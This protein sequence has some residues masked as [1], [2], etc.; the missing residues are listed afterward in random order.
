ML[1]IFASFLFIIVSV[2]SGADGRVIVSVQLGVQQIHRLILGQVL[3]LT[4]TC[5]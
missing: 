4:V 3:A 5:R 2:L 1:R